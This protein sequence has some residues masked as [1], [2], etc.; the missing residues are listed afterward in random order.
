[1]F[2]KNFGKASTKNKRPIEK[3]NRIVSQKIKR[4]PLIIRLQHN[5]CGVV[6]PCITASQKRI[7]SR[8]Q[9]KQPK[10]KSKQTTIFRTSF[11]TDDVNIDAVQ[12]PFASNKSTHDREPQSEN[13]A[14]NHNLS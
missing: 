9:T 6:C 3:R 2:E 13:S 12:H 7:P 8:D 11:N 14:A 5:M 10:K 1:M 4:K